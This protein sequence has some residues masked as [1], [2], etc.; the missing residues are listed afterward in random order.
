MHSS[1]SQVLHRQN[2]RLAG[3]LHSGL[4]FTFQARAAPAMSI[5]PEQLLNYGTA[6]SI[7][8][9]KAKLPNPHPIE[10]QFFPIPIPTSKAR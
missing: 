1:L 10:N 9:P 6:A 5:G 4:R 7:D 3:P 2:V 8:Q